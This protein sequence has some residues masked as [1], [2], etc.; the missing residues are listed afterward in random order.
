[1]LCDSGVCKTAEGAQHVY[2]PLPREREALFMLD[3]RVVKKITRHVDDGT[4][5][6]QNSAIIITPPEKTAINTPLSLSHVA[7]STLLYVFV[8]C[9][10]VM[11]Q[12]QFFLNK[13]FFL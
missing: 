8:G 3:T 4:V 7:C 12:K 6:L 5:G 2:H 11:S 10:V 1:M 9:H 13:G